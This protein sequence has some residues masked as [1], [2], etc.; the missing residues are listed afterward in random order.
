MNKLT[1]QLHSEYNLST[2]PLYDLWGIL[3]RRSNK[4]TLSAGHLAFKHRGTSV[5]LAIDDIRNV[6]I[7]SNWLYSNIAIGTESTSYRLNGFN[8]RQLES[9]I[10][11]IQR[12][13][14]NIFQHSA[15]WRELLKVVRRYQKGDHYF[16]S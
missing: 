6:K 16:S 2:H 4:I 3:R 12:A 1:P 8:V 15:E 9:L 13:A 7:K 14:L 10:Q 11:K 5:L